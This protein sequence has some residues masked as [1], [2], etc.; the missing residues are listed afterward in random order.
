MTDRATN[1]WDPVLRLLHWVTAICF[2]LNYW[3]LEQGDFW[4]RFVG[5]LLFSVVIVRLIWGF[6]G[7]PNARFSLTIFQFT[8]WQQHFQ[9]LNKRQVDPHEGHNPFGFMWLYLSLCLF[10][11]IAVTGF[12]LEEVDYFFGSDQLESIHGMLADTLFIFICVHV[13]AVFIV[14]WWGKISL[15]KPMLTGNRR[16]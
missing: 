5:Y 7:P 2:V 4:H 14:Q 15:I 16:Y 10:L 3:L 1:I 9:Q 13:L 11:S 12:L 8:R 6:T